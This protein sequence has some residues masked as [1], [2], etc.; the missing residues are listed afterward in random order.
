MSQMNSSKYMQTNRS[1]DFI[2]NENG[3]DGTIRENGEIIHKLNSGMMY[4]V[5]MIDSQGFPNMIGT[6]VFTEIDGEQYVLKRVD[7]IIN[8]NYNMLLLPFML[9]DR[10]IFGSRLG[11]S[12]TTGAV[13]D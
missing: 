4:D 13:A 10:Y 11:K 5:Y 2:L 1:I 12:I 3:Y 8:V 9:A 7:W 6:Y